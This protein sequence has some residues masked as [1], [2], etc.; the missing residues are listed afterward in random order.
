LRTIM[1]GLTV[2]CGANPDRSA[3]AG[4]DDRERSRPETTGPADPYPLDLA[5][6]RR[7]FPRHDKSATSPTGKYVAYAIETPTKYRYDVWTLPSGLLVPKLGTRL[8]VLE[9]ATGKSIAIGADGTASFTP[10]WSPDGTKLA[11]HSDQGGS[12]HAWIFDATKAKS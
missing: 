3:A 6:S 10:A 4:D 9:V 7:N 12:L 2:V 5:F 8:H 11:Y 1:I